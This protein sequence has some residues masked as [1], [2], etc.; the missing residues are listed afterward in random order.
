MGL[1]PLA[2]W[3]CG[4]ES[5][6]GHGCLSLASVVCCQVQVSATGRSLFQR[7]SIVCVCVCVCL[8]VCVCV[9]VCVCLCVCVCVCVCVRAHARARFCGFFVCVV[10]LCVVF[11]C[12]VCVCV[13]VCVC[14]HV[15][16][17][18]RSQLHKVLDPMQFETN[19]NSNKIIPTMNYVQFR[20]ACSNLLLL[21][22]YH[23]L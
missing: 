6:R 17:C 20:D 19:V 15:R 5:R 16:A 1:R 21:L 22:I 3:D 4:V 8:C 10:F 12:C 23:I 14:V 13:F 2:C 18:V 11:V 7:R 9:S